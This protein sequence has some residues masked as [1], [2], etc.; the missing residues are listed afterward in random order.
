[1]NHFLKTE[2]DKND[3]M[4]QLHILPIKFSFEILKNLKFLERLKIIV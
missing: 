4:N 3:F 2:V 1:M